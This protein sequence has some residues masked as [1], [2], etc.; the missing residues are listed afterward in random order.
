[1]SVGIDEKRVAIEAIATLA[2]LKSNMAKFVLFPAGVPRE[3]Y[4]TLSRQRDDLSGRT[5][6]KRQLAPLILANM[7]TSPDYGDIVRNI[8]KVAASWE[9]FELSHD[10]YEARAVKAKAQDVLKG[11]Q[12]FE[13]EQTERREAEKREKE[14]ERD[15]AKSREIGLLLEMF[16]SLALQDDNAQTRGYHL[17]DLLN[18]LF[19][20]FE[21]P[22]YESFTR[23]DG[24]EQI[25][26]AFQM[27]GWYYLTE[28]RWRRHHSDTSELDSLL[29]KISR[30]GRQ[31]MGLFLSINGWSLNVPNIL[32]QNPN[33][34]IILMH[35][36]DLRA[37]LSEKIELRDYMLS[38]VRNLN[39]KAEP[40]LAASSPSE[41]L[42]CYG[43][44]VMMG[45][46]SSM[47][48]RR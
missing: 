45:E 34:A 19:A 29:G 20:A 32:K 31:A 25:D 37:I 1:M 24:A 30:S 10:E 47:G 41:K 38:A 14:R 27:E 17:E 33:K 18:R 39:L 6:T 2:H 26:G 16:D 22:V 13:A 5:L 36:Y 23:N 40:Y 46:T 42:R 9:K 48:I 43:A 4:K 15:L 12:Q 3:I 44:G 21:I 11:V 7:E 35:G 28:C 8:V